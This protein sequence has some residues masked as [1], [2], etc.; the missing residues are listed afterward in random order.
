MI[1]AEE[2]KFNEEDWSDSESVASLKVE[3]KKLEDISDIVDQEME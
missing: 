1:K 3:K 2:R